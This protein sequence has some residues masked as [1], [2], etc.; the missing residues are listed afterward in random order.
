MTLR[1]ASFEATK[2]LF[3]FRFGHWKHLDA[4]PMHRQGFAMEELEKIGGDLTFLGRV[5]DFLSRFID[6]YIYMY[7]YVRLGVIGKTT[8]KKQSLYLNV[9]LLMADFLGADIDL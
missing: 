7:V 8:L 6:V 1:S 4:S 5:E 3:T 9:R 2:N